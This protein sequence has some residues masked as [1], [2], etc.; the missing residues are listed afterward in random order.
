MIRSGIEV[1]IT[2][3]TRNQVGGNVSWVRIPPTPLIRKPLKIGTFQGFLLCSFVGKNYIK[4]CKIVQ[5]YVSHS[6]PKKPIFQGFSNRDF[7]VC[8]KSVTQNRSKNRLVK[9]FCQL[10]GNTFFK[11]V[12]V[13]IDFNDHRSVFVAHELC[14][15]LDRYIRIVKSSSIVMSEDMGGQCVSCRG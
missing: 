4:L 3:L 14:G 15:H 1:V 10:I 13:S 2:A 11:L 7:Q 5:N 8:H 6:C 9:S 12:K